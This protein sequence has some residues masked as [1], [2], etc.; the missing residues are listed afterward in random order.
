MAVKQQNFFK[1]VIGKALG[2]VQHLLNEMLVMHIDRAGKIHHVAGV[3]VRH[4][5][6]NQ[7]L[8][9]SLPA[10]LQCHAVG[11]QH[12]YVQ[13]QVRSVLLHRAAGHN[14]N[15]PRRNGVINFRPRQFLVTMLSK[16]LVAHGAW[17]WGRLGGGL[18]GCNL[19]L[20]S[21]LDPRLGDVENRQK[22]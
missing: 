17:G 7:R 21:G 8:L 16:M 10:R 12:I 6:Q 4:T 1:A 3:A 15:L 20:N 9:R 18:T 11:K 13:R 14:A 19:G 2:D 22:Y 5:R